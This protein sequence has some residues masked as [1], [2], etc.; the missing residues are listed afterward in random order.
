MSSQNY[1]GNSPS[2]FT[3]PSPREDHNNDEN[4]PLGMP[5]TTTTLG[6]FLATAPDFLAPADFGNPASAATTTTQ[7]LESSPPTLTDLDRIL[8]AI[9][10]INARLDNQN[11]DINARFDGVAVTAQNAD[12]NTCFDGVTARFDALGD[13]LQAFESLSPRLDALDE[14]VKTT[15]GVLCHLDKCVTHAESLGPCLTDLDE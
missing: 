12:I 15:D 10:R 13:H 14:R 7:V 9:S 6:D 3:P 1:P 5:I 11:A 8:A 4:S 2:L